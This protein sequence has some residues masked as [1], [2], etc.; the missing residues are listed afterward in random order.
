MPLYLSPDRLR[1]MGLGVDLSAYTDYELTSILQ[2][3]SSAVNRVCAAP[4]Y[5]DEYDFRGGSVVGERHA[6]NWG[7]EVTVATRRFYPFSKPVKQIS[8]FRILVSEGQYLQLNPDDLF[9]NNGDG[10]VEVVALALGIG[11]FPV[12]AAM[13]LSTPVAEMDYTYGRTYAVTGERLLETDGQTFRGQHEWW[14]PSVAPVI[15]VNGVD[16]SGDFTID[17]DAGAAVHTGNLAATDKVTADYTHRMPFAIARA[18]GIIATHMIG[19]S[20]FAARGMIGVGRLKV[21]EVEISRATTATGAGRD[22]D[23]IPDEAATL[24]SGYVFRS[25]A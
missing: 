16:A 2:G 1:E 18:T 21:A 24:L 25:V 7:N 5:P 6:W 19:Q 4:T 13:S 14:E 8:Q 9:I 20:R 3:A 10:Y 11:V 23:S 12:V 15:K 22:D 17:F